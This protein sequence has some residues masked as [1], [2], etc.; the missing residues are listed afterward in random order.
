MSFHLINQKVEHVGEDGQIDTPSDGVGEL[1]GLGRVD[2]TQPGKDS[3]KQQRPAS[4][5]LFSLILKMMPH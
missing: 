1:P 5:T 3:G 4:A 2:P